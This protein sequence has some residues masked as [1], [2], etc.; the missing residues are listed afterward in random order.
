[1]SKQQENKNTLGA[2]MEFI[3]RITM[4]DGTV[5]E[6]KVSADGGIPSAEEMDLGSVDGFLKSF[7]KYERAAI[8]A[9]I[10]ICYE[11]IDCCVKVLAF[12]KEQQ[13]HYAGPIRLLS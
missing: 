7:D 6:K 2:Q 11:I 5:I 12:L 9:R 10:E 8:K 3:A 13:N 4:P 1:M